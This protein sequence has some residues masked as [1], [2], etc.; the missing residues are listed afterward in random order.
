[1]VLTKPFFPWA[2]AADYNLPGLTRLVD[3]EFHIPRLTDE[4]SVNE[5]LPLV[6]NVQRDL[7]V[8]CCRQSQNSYK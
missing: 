8:D 5:D 7:G 4:S 6:A 2:F 1:V 3:N